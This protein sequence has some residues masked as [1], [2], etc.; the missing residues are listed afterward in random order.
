LPE[1]ELILPGRLR[2]Q[3]CSASLCEPPQTITFE[4]PLTLQPFVIS[5]RDRELREQ[6]S[7]PGRGTSPADN[8]LLR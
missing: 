7:S 5:D 3:Q 1:G 2:F 8:Q 4:L 6:R